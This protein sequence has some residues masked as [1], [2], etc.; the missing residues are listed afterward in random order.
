MQRD[1][2]Q[3]QYAA[4]MARFNPAVPGPVNANTLF[5][6][7]IGTPAHVPQAYLCCVLTRR[8]VRI[9]CLHMPSRFVGSLDGKVT[10][11]DGMSFAFLGDVVHGLATTVIF[12]Q[13]AFNVTGNVRVLPLERILDAFQQDPMQQDPLHP[14][15]PDEADGQL[16]YTRMLMYLPMRYAPYFL[17]AGG[18]TVRQTWELL[19]PLL[20]ANDDLQNCRPLVDW[21]RIASYYLPPN[22]GQ[23]N[24]APP[25]VAVNLVAPTADAS[26]LEHR[27]TALS[28]ALPGRAQMGTTM[29]TALLTLA[30][31]VVAQTNDAR[32]AR[33]ANV[34]AREQPVLPST[35]YRNTIG[36]LLEYLQVPDEVNLP[37]LWHQWAN[38]DKKQE[39]TILKELLDASARQPNAFSTLT[40]VITPKLLQDLRTFTFLADS[41]DDLRTGLQP[42]IIADGSEEHR[43]ANLELARQYGLLQ[44]GATGVTFS[45]L[46][47]LE[48][49]EVK[50]IPLT[51]FDLEKTLGMFG[52]LLQVV[53]GSDHPLTTN[54]KAFWDL[55]TK[56]MRN[57]LQ[58]MID[59]TGKIK[60]AHVLRSTQLICHRWFAHKRARLQPKTPDFVDI[61]DRISLQAYILPHLPT[62][63]FR[64]AYPVPSSNRSVVPGNTLTIVTPTTSSSDHSVISA[65]TQTSRLTSQTAKSGTSGRGSFQANLNPDATLIQLVPGNVRLRDLMAN[66]TAPQTDDGSPMCLSFHLRSGCWSNCARLASHKVLSATEKQRLADFAL[67]QMPKV[68]TAPGAP[69]P[70]P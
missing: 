53:L 33:E 36:I 67:T 54:Y 15:E 47:A 25:A 58:L 70:A 55:L 18:Y 66:T 48:A 10:P 23:P 30:Q 69:Q 41:P 4:I 7:A 21:L 57:D 13:N 68:P 22:N 39:H 63:L 59:T 9:H 44:E 52:N 14:V 49:K 51:Y 34:A 6:Q 8:G 32:M 19:I 1:P 46:Q 11:W 12:P 37:Q 16:A 60:P 65:L 50:S 5:E 27:A 43:R 3:G 61:L 35:K 64:L 29:E 31:S 2:C 62:A 56:S 20:Q 38:S 24:L 17:D 42:F 40:P 45:D 26:L 28:L